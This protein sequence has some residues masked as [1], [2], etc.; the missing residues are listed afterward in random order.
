M[1]ASVIADGSG[2]VAA[3]SLAPGQA[4]ELPQAVG[5]LARLPGVPHWV[6]ADRGHTSHA[7]RK[8]IWNLGDRLV[9]HRS[10][11]R[12]RLPVPSGSQP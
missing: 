2:R 1:E 12:H 3:V 8:H 11:T 10:G 6:V 4:H 9:I 5:L 7:F